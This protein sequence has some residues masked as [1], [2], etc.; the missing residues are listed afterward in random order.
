MFVTQKIATSVANILS[1]KQKTLVLGNLDAQRDWGHARDF[2]FGVWRI[3]QHGS[4]E[5]FVICSGETHSVREFTE[6]AFSAVGI[7][8]RYGVG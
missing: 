1:G 2:M 3:M 5:D 6:L 7:L 8:L 4:P